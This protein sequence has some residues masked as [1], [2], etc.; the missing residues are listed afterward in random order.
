MLIK[1]IL[2][3]K[4]TFS[5]A[6]ELTG[7]QN[8]CELLNFLDQYPTLQRPWLQSPTKTLTGN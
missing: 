8:F 1:N 7:R 2:I 4:V 5:Q 6:F 3:G